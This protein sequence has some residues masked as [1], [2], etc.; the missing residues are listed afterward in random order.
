VILDFALGV[1][2]AGAAI[3]IGAVEGGVARRGY[4]LVLSD[5]IAAL[6][7][8]ALGLELSRRT[9]GWIMPILATLAFTYV[10]LWGPWVDGQFFFVGLPWESAVSRSIYTDEG[11]FGII[12]NIS[13]RVVALFILLGAFLEVSG[14]AQAVID[15]ARALVG[16][17]IGGPGFVAVA[18]SGMMGTISGSAAANTAGTGVITIPLMKN[19]GFKPK[20]AAGVEAAASTGG[21]LTPPIMGAGVFVMASITGV[22]YVDLIAVAAL[23]ALLYFLSVAIWIRIEAKKHGVGAADAAAPPIMETLKRGG[24]TFIVPIGLL[25]GLLAMGFTPTFAAP[26]AIL[27]V[28]ATSWLTPQRMGPKAI[29]KA[30]SLGAR[31]TILVGVLLVVVGL[32]VNALATAGVGPTLSQMMKEWA[33]GDLLIALVLIALASLVLGMGLPVTAAYIVLATI[34]APALFDLIL[35]ADLMA[36]L[37]SGGAPDQAKALAMLAVPDAMTQLSGPMSPEDAA[38]LVAAL[39]A[40]VA[41]SFF[42]ALRDG[43]NPAVVTTA[44]VSAHMIIFWLSQDSNVTPPV[45]LT[46]FIAASI[47]GSRPMATGM[48]AWRIA[49][50]LYI[51][52]VLFAFTPF[53]SGEFDAALR[54]FAFGLVG[55]YALTA[56]LEGYAETPINPP[57]RVV[58]PAAGVAAL[59]PETIWLNVAG[60]ATAIA[61]VVGLTLLERDRFNRSRCAAKTET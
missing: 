36:L 32:I 55:V 51:V 40:E 39:P 49:K 24:V 35:Q 21:Q 30:L 3:F 12:A 47:A 5:W 17:V 42:D 13:V 45:C 43:L 29:L 38:A 59:W 46:A 57:L 56:A 6:I 34:S 61:I 41:P 54:I 52:P 15:V 25:V 26:F 58:L 1:L 2:V 18:A 44:I 60:A 27:A 31:N 50:G 4:D 16:R 20:F 19:A 10:T 53:L 23:P 8:I 48:T 28:I 33:G 11:M 7:V 22:P 9:T 37:A 14:A